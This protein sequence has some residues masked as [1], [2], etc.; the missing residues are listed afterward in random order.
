MRVRP[1]ERW[2]TV[3][4][5]G[6][7]ARLLSGIPPRLSARVFKCWWDNKRR[8]YLIEL[9]D[10]VHSVRVPRRLMGLDECAAYICLRSD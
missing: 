10:P 5:A 4:Q 7:R 1:D 2:Y 8:E 3:L 6:D 9:N